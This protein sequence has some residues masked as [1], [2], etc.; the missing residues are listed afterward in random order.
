[1]EQKII[2][3]PGDGI[4][5]EVWAAAES[6][7][8]ELRLPWELEVHPEVN[9][10][11]WMQE[12]EALSDELLDRLRG[13]EYAAILFG[14]IGHPKAPE[15]VVERE[16]LLRL[17]TELDL[18]INARPLRLPPSV[19][20]PLASGHRIDALVIRENTEG[21]YAG[22]GG[23]L[24]SGSPMDCAMTVSVTTRHGAMRALR[25]GFEAARDRRAR[26]TLVHKA[27]VLRD[28]GRLWR[29]CAD[30]IAAELPDVELSYSH[31]DVALMRLMTA[32]EDFDVIVTD[33]IFGDLLTD[34]G[35]AVAG[36]LGLAPSGNLNPATGLAL[37]EPVHGSAFDIAGTGAADP[38]AMFRC[39][40]MC[41][42][43]LG[44]VERADAL[45]GALDRAAIP[46]ARTTQA[47]LG[48]VR[49]ELGGMALPG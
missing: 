24:R 35:A 38:S 39:V 11:R 4:G 19:A 1:M 47:V 17:R 45:D 15:G 27:N 49:R 44:H 29:E 36:G 26:L 6:V 14:A 34:L 12:G 46:D 8:D 18:A 31:A 3:I 5:P 43:H 7:I 48:A 40:A 41:A 16:V 20:S 2:A 25:Y 21:A 10:N 23:R 33:N 32:P 13:H 22:I 30:E 37:F 42:R 28:E 9:S